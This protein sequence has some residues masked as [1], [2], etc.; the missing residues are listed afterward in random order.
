VVGPRVE[1]G[2]TLNARG[3][4]AYKVRPGAELLLT[5]R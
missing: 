2:G 4:N 1:C 5:V 3:P